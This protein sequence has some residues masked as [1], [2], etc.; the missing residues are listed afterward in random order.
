MGL[1][2]DDRKAIVCY[3]IEKAFHTLKEHLIKQPEPLD[4]LGCLIAFPDAALEGSSLVELPVMM[5]HRF[6]G[7]PLVCSGY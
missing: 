6:N 3:R 4:V 1:T 2:D 7:V 5:A